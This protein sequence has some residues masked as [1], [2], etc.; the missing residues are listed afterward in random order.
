MLGTYSP[1]NNLAITGA[2]TGVDFSY[3][4][5]NKV[6]VPWWDDLYP[7]AVPNGTLFWREVNNILYIQWQQIGHFATLGGPFG[8][9]ITFQIQIVQ[10]T[11]GVSTIHMVYSDAAFGG[12]QFGN[13]LAASATVGYVGGSPALNYQ[14]SYQTAGAIQNG[15]SLTISSSP[16]FDAGWSSPSGPGSLL[17]AVCVGSP[18]GAYQLFATVNQGLFPNG[19]FFGLDMT[20]P[21]VL[22]Q[23]NVFPFKGPLNGV[24]AATIGPFMGLPP[25]LPIY[26]LVFNIPP[27]SVPTIHTPPFAYTIP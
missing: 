24:G 20:Y 15:T 2:T 4:A 22:S 10:K 5:Q 19:W 7:T 21:E 6:V 26:S 18:N 3:A 1:F 11:C 12:D 9:A 25:G 17:I 16:Q 23:F 14:W 8:P 13:D 27:G